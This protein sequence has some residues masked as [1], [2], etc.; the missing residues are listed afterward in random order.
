MLTGSRYHIQVCFTIHTLINYECV[1]SYVLDRLYPAKA[2]LIP[3]TYIALHYALCYSL[4]SRTFTSL[5]MLE[6]SQKLDTGCMPS[7]LIL[8]RACSIIITSSLFFLFV[9][10]KLV[11][12][13]CSGGRTIL[14]VSSITSIYVCISR[15]TSC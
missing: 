5:L 4:L 1:D 2:I 3:I 6:P 12:A 7:L 15:A 9:H 11:S 13:L 14:I 8:L 10:F